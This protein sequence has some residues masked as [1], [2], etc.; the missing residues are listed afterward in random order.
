M[1]K[2]PERSLKLD[3]P[4]RMQFNLTTAV[5]HVVSMKLRV[6]LSEKQWDRLNQ[7]D[8]VE[9]VKP[10]LREAGGYEVEYHK[11]RG[12]N[13]FFTVAEMQSVYGVLDVINKL[14]GEA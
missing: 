10:A 6:P 7:L 13:L 3:S 5:A 9:K 11:S 2:E 14:V 8:A 4:Q 1:N 12:M